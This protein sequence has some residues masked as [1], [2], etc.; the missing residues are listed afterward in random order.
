MGS[1]LSHFLTAFSLRLLQPFADRSSFFAGIDVMVGKNN[2]AGLNHMRNSL[3]AVSQSPLPPLTTSTH[4][5]LGAESYSGS[6][7]SGYSNGTGSL[8]RNPFG[9]GVW[10]RASPFF[11]ILEPLARPVDLPPYPNHRNQVY[12]NFI[13]SQHNIDRM[14]ADS[15]LRV[16]L[17]CAAQPDDISS[18]IAPQDISFPTQLEV[19]VNEQEVRA[20]FKG[21]KNKP[22]ST[23]PAD[24][25]GFVTKQP[26]FT[27]RVQVTYA[28]TQ[29]A[30]TLMALLVKKRS[31]DELVTRIKHGKVITREKVLS[32]MQMRAKDPDIV[33]SSSVMSLKDPVSYMRI[34]VPCRSDVCSHH[35][36]FDAASFLQLQE[37]APTWTCPICNKVVSFEGLVVDQ[38][39]EDIL[40]NTSSSTY[41]VTVEPDGRW[42]ANTSD[43]PAGRNGFDNDSADEDSNDDIVEVAKPIKKESF[44][45]NVTPVT[46]FSMVAPTPPGV[47]PM[48]SN[49]APSR[50]SQGQ[51]RK[52]EVID[53]TLSDDDDEPPSKRQAYNTPNSL[54]DHGSRSGR[55]NGYSYPSHA[56][57]FPNRTN[58]PLRFQIGSSSSR[59][60]SGGSSIRNIGNSIHNNSRNYGVNMDNTTGAQHHYNHDHNAI[61][62]TTGRADVIF[63]GTSNPSFSQ[64]RSGSRASPLSG[65]AL[66]PI[67]LTES[68][69][70]RPPSALGP[71]SAGSLFGRAPDPPPTL[72]RLT[73]FDGGFPSPPPIPA[74][75]TQTQRANAHLEPSQQSEQRSILRQLA[76]PF[77]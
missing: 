63:G 68:P 4:S 73:D 54:S 41:Q 11:E 50:P 30:F 25:T 13:L 76:N 1:A 28:L 5:Q 37:Q 19:K 65:S 36:C 44:G 43:G 62:A 45:T 67:N 10:F 77:R 7:G 2:I 17:Y 20:N 72:P 51:K 74:S 52:S 55:T 75:A 9:S 60:S 27:N 15:S 66:A 56:S 59:D 23:R 42:S 24:V 71:Y 61:A 26:Q 39:F 32:E 40:Q 12:I 49:S 70:Q 33:V 22:G 58:G 21:V 18:A 46:P 47:S 8:S 69:P 6:S 29:K 57:S 64:S 53:L 48:A 34:S 35:Q 14:R 16:L 3:L 38:Y 31:V